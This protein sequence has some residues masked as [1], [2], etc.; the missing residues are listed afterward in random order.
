MLKLTEHVGIT[1]FL[2]YKQKTR[3]N[4]DIQNFYSKILN[5]LDFCLFFAKKLQFSG[6]TCFYDAI[7][8]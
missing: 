1:I 3:W 8:T 6:P 2:L 4:S 7:T 5:F